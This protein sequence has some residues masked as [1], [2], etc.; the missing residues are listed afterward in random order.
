MLPY[1]Q[2]HDYINDYIN[3]WNHN[4]K[5]AKTGMIILGIVLALVGLAAAFTPFSMYG[6]V[7]GIVAAALI[8]HGIGQ[9]ATYLQTPEFFRSGATLASGILNAILGVLFLLLPASFTAGTLVFLLAF[10]LIMT[11]VERMSF[12]RQMS[13]YGIPAS[14]MGGATGIL[15][16]IL[17]VVFLFMPMVSSIVLSYLIAA[18]LIVGGITLVV[19]GIS[20]KKIDR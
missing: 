6:I 19:E 14:S 7:Q 1:D 18:Y 2:N 20:I 17:G 12:S 5:H 10:L 8:V 4:V 16:I 9:I 11:G 13:F 3:K 15:N